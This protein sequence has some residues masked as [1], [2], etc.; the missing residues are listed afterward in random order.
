MDWKLFS[1]QKQWLVDQYYEGKIGILA[2]R[3]YTEG[4][5]NLMEGIQD[6]AEELGYRER[7]YPSDSDALKGE[8]HM[9]F[10]E[11]KAGRYFLDSQIPKLIS[12]V[13]NLSAAVSK[14]QEVYT[15]PVERP[16]NYLED[17]Y[18]GNVEI[19]VCSDKSVPNRGMKEIILLQDKL[20]S[21]F[22][23]EQWEM[24]LRYGSLIN[25]RE[26]EETS[27]MFQHGFRLAVNLIVAGL[28][29]PQV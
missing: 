23:K 7:M 20:K 17:L 28:Q 13:E 24:F 6:M 11:T 19:G 4:I 15:L 29:N 8:N 25:A 9:N 16:E 14:K 21:K 27:R 18:Y 2:D 5:L 1:E 22:T 12:A 10:H 26:L 3:E